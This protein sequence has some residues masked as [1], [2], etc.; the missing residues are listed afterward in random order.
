LN[1]ST[2]W[3][4]APP[5]RADNLD[6]VRRLEDAGAPLLVLRSFFEEQLAQEG[7]NVDLAPDAR[8]DPAP[9]QFC[10]RL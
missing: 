5:P 3:C 1:C 10:Y 8:L 9:L 4:P 2:R 6:T 7:I